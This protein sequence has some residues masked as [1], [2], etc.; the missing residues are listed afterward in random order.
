MSARPC[1]PVPL[2][3][4]T[5]ALPLTAPGLLLPCH[6]VLLTLPPPP[7][8]LLLFPCRAFG[9]STDAAK[10]SINLALSH[11]GQEAL[12][13]VGVLPAVMACTVPMP[14]RAIHPAGGADI[15]TQ[16]YGAPGQ[17]IHS[18]SRGLVNTALLDACSAQPGRIHLHFGAIVA[19]LDESG[20]LTLG[21]DQKGSGQFAPPPPTRPRRGSG[22]D[23]A[24]SKVRDSMLRFSRT[25]YARTFID[26][27]YKELS[28]PAT[29]AGGSSS[30][31]S[32]GGG[33]SSSSGGDF[34]LA[35]PHS[36]HIWP[37][38]DFMLIALPNLDRSFT[39]TLFAKFQA[40]EQLEA[41]GEG[42]QRAFFAA[43]FPDV[44]P[45][46]PNLHAQFSANPTS[47]LLEVKCAPWHYK[48]RVLLIGDAAHSTVPFY[49]Q[50]MN[51]ALEDCLCFGEAFDAGAGA[52]GLAG[53]QL[54]AAVEAFAASR[55]PA[56]LALCDLSMG[57]YAEMRAKTASPAFLLRSWLESAF[58]GSWVNQALGLGWR[59]QYSMVAFSRIPYH[60]VVA[61]VAAQEAAVGYALGA[62]GVGLGL[63]VLWAA[64]AVL[65][66][67]RRGGLGETLKGLLAANVESAKTTAQGVVGK[68]RGLGEKIKALK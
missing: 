20:L 44:L 35:Q 32:S 30:S 54:E 48:R 47:S 38:G 21:E 55:Q 19:S 1:W 46:L 16:P 34:A 26:H 56:G 49:G 64:S 27:G 65:G 31:S 18:V 24:G 12:R 23:G 52:V 42:A 59:S 57:N 41:G 43:H 58:A 68:L 6:A 61:R 62:L 25:N 3:Q 51:A 5:R 29:A 15:V 39:A 60:E 8:P 33:S 40:F 53:Q 17:A 9:Q 22:A 13:A 66:D 4:F 67:G 63:G 11:R 14:Q 36:L 45:L 2:R 37:R 50:G 7:P 10:R 28:I